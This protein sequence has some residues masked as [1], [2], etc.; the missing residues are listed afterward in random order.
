MRRPFIHSS[1]TVVRRPKV[2]VFD[3]DACLWYPEM[4]MMS[5]GP[6]HVDIKRRWPRFSMF[7]VMCDCLYMFP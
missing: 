7:A 1:V 6:F 5:G 3:L 2:V 4:Y